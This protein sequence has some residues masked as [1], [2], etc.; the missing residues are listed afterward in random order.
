MNFEEKRNYIFIGDKLNTLKNDV[1]NE[2]KFLFKRLHE[3]CLLYKNQK[4]T[5]E[6]PNGSST[7]MSMGALNFSLAFM[8][9]KQKH[10]LEEAKRWIMTGVK[11]PHWGHAHL[12]DVDLSASWLL[13][14]YSLCYDWL[15]DELSEED[16]DMLKNKLILQGTRMYDF[17]LKTVGEGWST[18]YWQNHNWI[19]F[20]GLAAVGY[21]LKGEVS[22]A[23]S[24][25]EYSKENF[26]K[27]FSF[28]PEDGSDY[29]GVA[30]WRYGVLWLYIY[31]DLLKEREKIDY[32]K[33]CDFLKNT[34]F[35]RLY[36]STPN[37]EEIINFGDCHDRRSGHSPAI[38]FKVASE[39]INSYAQ[40]LGKL[41]I[42]KF[43]YREQYE[44]GIK[45]GILSEA[46][47][48]LLWFNPNIGI[49]NFDELPLIKY[50]EDLGLVVI[51][52]SWKEDGTIFSFKCGAPGG[53]KQWSKS[54][55]LDI[56][57]NWK[58]R[59]LSHQHPDN[60][61]FIIYG[62]GAFLSIDDGYNRDVKASEHNV[63]V[64]D[65]IGYTSENQNNIWKET[66]FEDIGE[67]KSFFHENS[68]VYILGESSK[69]YEKH[70]KFK[71]FKRHIINTKEKH[72][73]II[74]EL[75]SDIPHIYSWLHHSD[76]KGEIRGNKVEIL[77]GE[78]EIDIYSLVPE[79][80]GK[81][82]Y[83]TY[84]K[85]I[86]TTQEPDKYREL[87]MSTL[88]ISNV[89]PE[90]ELK[91]INILNV[92]STFEKS[93][94]EEIVSEETEGFN[95]IF[96][97]KKEFEEI[98]YFNKNKSI[99][100]ENFSTDAKTLVIKKVKNNFDI[101]AVDCTYLDYRSNHLYRGE[102]K[103]ITR[104]VKIDEY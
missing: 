34:F 17:A 69:S 45:P 54:W 87:N 38:Y 14:G 58:T 83:N 11:Y 53:K 47:L 97:R 73:Y 62:N 80:N 98:F 9:T 85:A 7:F 30:Y 75:S 60:N 28:M 48:E 76:T 89:V 101:L 51:K 8:I 42:E 55:E 91:F 90:K 71:E 2:K 74:D 61:S 27:V 65:D 43:L 56:A 10:Y 100:E 70:L 3:Q 102:K 20:T 96:I 26:L 13:F 57:Y 82:I 16:R 77:N 52:D 95:R 33:E 81:S 6:H 44:S 79:N 5:E 41:V 39:Y 104:K 31:A 37:L 50:W 32:F 93:S 88:K 103:I 59:G 22:E 35:Y 67:I 23:G 12:V 66:K 49:R 25:I 64:V 86:M 24:W 15:K 99:I 4:L 21:A 40:N 63:V 29:E 1:K 84:I 19:N 92:N 68:Y 94:L 78:A 72:F 46:W 36:Q 18:N